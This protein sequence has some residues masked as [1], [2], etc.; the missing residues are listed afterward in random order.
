MFTT[1]NEEKRN[2][3]W[4]LATAVSTILIIVLA[5]YFLTKI[6]TD[7]PLAGTWHHEDS[8]LVLSISDDGFADLQWK[9]G[10]DIS[11]VQVTMK[12]S[13]D[14]DLKT[15]VL[16]ADETSLQEA[17]AQIKDD[18]LKD[19]IRSNVSAL[20]A[21]YDYSVEQHQL[22]LTDREYGEQLIFDRK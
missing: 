5:V 19:K 4:Q 9:D 7:N 22:I 1:N 20:S 8:D 11:K 14:K 2:K 12:Y 10:E 3:I 15:F 18:Q 6:F 17:Q 16:S 21:T 13:M